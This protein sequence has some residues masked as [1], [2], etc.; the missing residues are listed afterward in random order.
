MLRSSGWRNTFFAHPQRI[1]TAACVTSAFI[2]LIPTCIELTP[3]GRIFRSARGQRDDAQAAVDSTIRRLKGIESKISED[4]QRIAD[5][6]CAMTGYLGFNQ[7]ASDFLSQI[8]GSLASPIDLLKSSWQLQFNSD[9]NKPE[10]FKTHKSW[11]EWELDYYYSCWHSHCPKDSNG[12]EESCCWAWDHHYVTHYYDQ[13][14]RIENRFKNIITGSP[15]HIPSLDCGFYSRQFKT[16][17][18]ENYVTYESPHID[19]GRR[20]SGTTYVDFFREY[21]SRVK[22]SFLLDGATT[23]LMVNVVRNV[24]MGE[25][26]VTLA[27][28]LQ[29]FLSFAIA[30]FNMAGANYPALQDGFRQEIPKL[31]TEAASVNETLQQQLLVLAE[32]QASLDGSDDEYQH[33]LNLWLPLLFLLPPAIGLLVF[34]LISLGKNFFDN[35][36]FQ[37]AVVRLD[38]LENPLDIE[39]AEPQHKKEEPQLGSSAPDPEAPPTYRAE[40]GVKVDDEVAINIEPSAPP[41]PSYSPRRM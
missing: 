22:V 31:L 35:E 33:G 32:K 7:R 8:S 5:L 40:L 27:E 26:A 16:F 2:F 38:N 4:K 3:L 19:S 34:T 39:L 41:P 18:P 25:A 29:Q 17:S 24:A 11:D 15:M 10:Q 1:G 23:D 30:A 36:D 21:G 13:I 6:D 20:T 12:K 37:A 14:T 9:E 28:N